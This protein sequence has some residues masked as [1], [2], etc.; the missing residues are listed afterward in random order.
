M[1][2][3]RLSTENMRKSR[4]KVDKLMTLVPRNHQNIPEIVVKIAK[5]NF[6]QY[7]E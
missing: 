1:S 4:E 5:L 2:V 7:N 3:S 6:H